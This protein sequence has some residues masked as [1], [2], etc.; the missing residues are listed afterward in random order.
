MDSGASALIRKKRDGRRRLS[1]RSGAEAS[2]GTPTEGAMEVATA[3]VDAD[4]SED[5]LNGTVRLPWKC[6]TCDKVCFFFQIKI[7]FSAPHVFFSYFQTLLKHVFIF[8]DGDWSKKI[9]TVSLD[10]SN[11]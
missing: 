9:L 10:M 11:S 6:Q 4:A 7:Q 1:D 5:A 2:S 8:T 3:A